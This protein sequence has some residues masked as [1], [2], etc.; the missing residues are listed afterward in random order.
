MGSLWSQYLTQR[1]FIVFSMDPEKEWQGKSLK[2]Y[3]GDMSKYLTLIMV[4][5]RGI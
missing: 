3:Y 1:G 4:T 2:I 5:R